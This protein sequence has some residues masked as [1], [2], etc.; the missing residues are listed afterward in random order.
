[1]NGS[2][3]VLCL[4]IATG[5]AAAAFGVRA[6]GEAQEATAEPLE[7]DPLGADR[8]SPDQEA[9]AKAPRPTPRPPPTPI[10]EAAI[11]ALAVPEPGAPGTP[12]ELRAWALVRADHLIEAREAAETA[13]QADA[14]SYIAHFVLGYVYHYAEASFPRALYHEREALRLFVRRHDNPPREAWRWHARI[15][16]EMAATQ[17]DL[18]NHRERLALIEEYNVLYDPDVVAETAWAL[19]KL[20][21]FDDARS[22]ARAGIETGDPRQLEISLNALCAVEFEAGNDSASYDACRRALDHAR[23]TPGEPNAVD[24]TNFAE[25]ARAAF[26]LAE[27]E[28]VLLE[29]TRAP[30]AWYV[31]PWLELAELYTRGARF[32]EALD[33]L[34]RVNPYRAQ[35]PPHVRDSDLNEGRRALAAFFLV[36]GRAADALEI[37][38][39][40]LVAPDRRGHNSRDPAQDRAIIALLDRRA[41]RV[42]AETTIEQSSALGFTTRAMAHAEAWR[43]RF[44]GWMSGRQAV[45]LLAEED[46]LIGT[47]KLGTSSSAVTPPWLLGEL[48]QIAGA[49]VMLEALRRADRQ[50]EREGAA[51]YYDAVAA[52]A[53]LVRGDE[54]RAEELATRAREGFGPGEA[55]LQA[56]TDAVRAVAMAA[57]TGVESALPAFERALAKDPGVFRR[58][59][60]AL[61]IRVRVEGDDSTRDV[62]DALSRSPRFDVGDVGLELSVRG[63]AASVEVCLQG[64]SG[65][66]LGCVTQTPR[67]DEPL[68][69]FVQ[70]AVNAFHEAIFAPRI[71]LSQGDIHG[72]DGSN[73]VGRDALEDLLGP[74][75]H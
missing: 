19:M 59:E 10:D 35:R 13:L 47:C 16:R 25:A 6:S 57:Q 31:N 43:G 29:A 71:D 7:T 39:K 60:I 34:R 61:P 41:R 2:A 58:L 69:I 23:V 17:G 42:V 49:G 36:V 72:L 64:G 48:V 9:P 27:A 52:E 21:R 40:A 63:S 68:D 65:N 4:A 22:A 24:L 73:R 33:A 1:M 70:S 53:A 14:T 37:T 66:A 30:P 5:L 55:L 26:R 56:R 32:P 54:A 46:R 28:E 11:A 51:P 75:A 45:R 15:L 62:A 8:S 44:E 18:E 50:D 74:G 67:T 20:G 3:R 12:Q 38:D